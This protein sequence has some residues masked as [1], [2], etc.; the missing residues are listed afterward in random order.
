MTLGLCIKVKP[1]LSVPA[2]LLRD[3]GVPDVDWNDET[4]VPMTANALYNAGVIRS[5]L[6]QNDRAIT[7]FEAYAKKYPANKGTKAGESTPELIKRIAELHVR[8]GSLE[9]GPQ[10]V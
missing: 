10:G 8:K 3:G 4:G 7:I 1:T 2:T 5:A 9:E 6:E